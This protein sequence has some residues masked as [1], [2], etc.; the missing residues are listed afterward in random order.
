METEAER[1]R[2][3]LDL[4]RSMSDRCWAEYYAFVQPL[5][6]MRGVAEPEELRLMRVASDWTGRIYE[7]EH[8]LASAEHGAP[9]VVGAHGHYQWLTLVRSDISTLLELCPEVVLNRYLA[10]TSIDSGTLKLTDQEKS[11]GWWTAENARVFSGCDPREDR[12]EVAYS[13]RLAS[14]HGLPNETHEECCAGFDEWYV[15][16]QPAPAVEMEAFVNWGGYRLYDP[17]W[18]WCADRF[19]EQMGRLAPESYIADGTVFTFVTRNDQLFRKVLAAFSA[20]P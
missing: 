9:G 10:V 14:V 19:W 6:P 1:A 18:K 12:G 13:P 2:Q 5:D 17:V 8:A 11:E 15:F 7:A 16:D 20:V 3:Q 4:A